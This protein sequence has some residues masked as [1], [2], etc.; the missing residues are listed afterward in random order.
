MQVLI[1]VCCKCCSDSLCISNR[2]ALL[3]LRQSCSSCKKLHHLERFGETAYYHRQSGLHSD[4]PRSDQ[5]AAKN[6]AKDCLLVFLHFSPGWKIAK[7]KLINEQSVYRVYN[8]QR[9]AVQRQKTGGNKNICAF[10]RRTKK[11]W[12][13]SSATLFWH[14]YTKQGMLTYSES[15]EK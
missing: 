9:T 4:T 11:Q 15:E 14:K 6:V 10:A 2:S 7:E 5:N 1:Q 3:F 8:E 13:Q 12:S